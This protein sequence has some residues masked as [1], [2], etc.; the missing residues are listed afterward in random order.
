MAG[1]LKGKRT[2][3][4]QNATNQMSLALLRYA[5]FNE[6]MNIISNKKCPPTAS[7]PFAPAPDPEVLHHI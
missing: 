5:Y 1:L 6:E 4:L 2:Y 7:S 3:K